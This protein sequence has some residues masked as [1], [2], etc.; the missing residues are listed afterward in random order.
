MNDSGPTHTTVTPFAGV[1]FVDPDQPTEPASVTVSLSAA[2]NGQFTAASSTLAGW[3]KNG[4]GTIYSFSGTRADAEAALQALVFSPT[5]HQVNPG[6]TVT[7]TFTIALTEG[8][9]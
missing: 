1:T 5:A 2:A 4:P 7:T 8:A 3:T 9:I 6:S